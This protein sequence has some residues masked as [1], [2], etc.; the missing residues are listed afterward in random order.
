MRW[1]FF[2]TLREKIFKTKSGP[3]FQQPQL[4]RRGWISKVFDEQS[5]HQRHLS[6][7]LDAGL[8]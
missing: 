6:D 8:H 5:V 2:K 7:L 3:D 1:I 4:R